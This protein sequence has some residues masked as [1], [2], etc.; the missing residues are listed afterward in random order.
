MLLIN[1][2][3]MVQWPSSGAMVRVFKKKK[4]LLLPWEW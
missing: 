4:D 3:V 1:P 2:E